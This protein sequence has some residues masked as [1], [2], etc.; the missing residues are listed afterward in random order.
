MA[1]FFFYRK[2]LINADAQVDKIFK[3]LCSQENDLI[4]PRTI[5]HFGRDLTFSKT[6]GQVLDSTFQELCDRVCNFLNIHTIM[7]YKFKFPIFLLFLFFS[8]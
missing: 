2:S 4:R 5:T 6:C 7:L 8:H 3:I 1:T